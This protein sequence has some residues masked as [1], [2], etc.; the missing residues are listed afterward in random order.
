MNSWKNRP[1]RPPIVLLGAVI[2]SAYFAY[3][4]AFGTHGLQAK[5]RLLDRMETLQRETAVLEVVRTR[6]QQDVAA[7]A[8]DPPHPDIVEETA[9]AL[10][11]WSRPGDRIVQRV[12]RGGL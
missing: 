8:S 3:H 2:A 12:R 10:F 1:R 7:L 6:L 5:A 9:R 11:G 4:A